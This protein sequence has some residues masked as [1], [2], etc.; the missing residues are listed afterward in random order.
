L[1]CCRRFTRAG[2]AVGGLRG[3]C[4]LETGSTGGFSVGSRATFL[5]PSRG[6]SG[7]PQ[8]WNAFAMR[9]R[10]A[11]TVWSPTRES[12]PIGAI[13]VCCAAGFAQDEPGPENAGCKHRR[14]SAV[15]ELCTAAP[16][17]QAWAGFWFAWVHQWRCSRWCTRLGVRTYVERKGVGGG[18]DLASG[19]ANKLLAVWNSPLTNPFTS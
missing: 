15:L 16:V 3:R 7:G 13:S 2:D 14:V 9:R 4:A 5:R 17:H 19:R 11:D 10:S 1:S 12:G 18:R 6:G 8:G